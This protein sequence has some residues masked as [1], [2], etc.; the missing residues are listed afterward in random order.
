MMKHRDCHQASTTTMLPARTSTAATRGLEK[1]ACCGPCANWLQSIFCSI[2][3]LIE[4]AVTRARSESSDGPITSRDI[5][6][7]DHRRRKV[8]PRSSRVAARTR[9]RRGGQKNSLVGMKGILGYAQILHQD[10][11]QP[12][13]C[14]GAPV[15]SFKDGR[16]TDIA[17]ATVEK[18]GLAA[19]LRVRRKILK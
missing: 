10:F 13:D 9:A 1:Y 7:L 11:E 4:A 19:S 14:G 2:S 12:N 16:S 5:P 3:N 6:S 18:P 17:L 8:T 15:P